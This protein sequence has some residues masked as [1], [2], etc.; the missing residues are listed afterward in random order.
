MTVDIR[1]P[2]RY[3]PASV[4]A[5]RRPMPANHVSIIFFTVAQLCDPIMGNQTA[6]RRKHGF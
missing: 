4:S 2:N 5:G 6:Y 3:M 1:R